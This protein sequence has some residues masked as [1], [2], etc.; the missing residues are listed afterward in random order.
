MSVEDL[1]RGTDMRQK[2]TDAVTTAQEPIAEATLGNNDDF[3]MD[4]GGDDNLTDPR[5]EQQQPPTYANAASK[6]ASAKRPRNDG[7]GSPSAPQ[8][9]K[10]ANE[11]DFMGKKIYKGSPKVVT[12]VQEG[13]LPSGGAFRPPPAQRPKPDD[14][15][16]EHEDQ[17]VAIMLIFQA[18]CTWKNVNVEIKPNIF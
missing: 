9:K 6:S 13:W 3:F 10:S 14:T 7:D 8:A 16:F 12:K 4:F 17:N 18:H 15:S 5:G 1:Q 2:A 11:I